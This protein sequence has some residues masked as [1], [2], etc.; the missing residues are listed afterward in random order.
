MPLLSQVLKNIELIS[1]FVFRKQ[2][3]VFNISFLGFS[4]KLQKPKTL[5]CI[6]LFREEAGTIKHLFFFFSKGTVN[7]KNS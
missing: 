4:A 3:F 7:G 6:S 2:C 5:L 1:H